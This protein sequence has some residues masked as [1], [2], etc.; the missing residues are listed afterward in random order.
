MQ[1]FLHQLVQLLQQAITAIF[2]LVLWVHN[3]SFGK[4]I[5]LINMQWQNWPLMKQLI[6]LIVL[7]AI[8]YFLYVGVKQIWQALKQLFE[9]VIGFAMVVMKALPPFAF[10]GGIALVGGWVLTT[11][12]LNWF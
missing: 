6:F 8:G 10:A 5:A 3:W 4:I 12:R 11:F 1:Q 7:G 2:D 9:A